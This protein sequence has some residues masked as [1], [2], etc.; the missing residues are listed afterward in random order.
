MK[1][2]EMQCTL[3]SFIFQSSSEFFFFLAQYYFNNENVLDWECI[4]I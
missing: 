2:D 4:K 3:Y 1:L